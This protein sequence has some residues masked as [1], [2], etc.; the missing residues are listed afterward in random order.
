MAARTSEELGE[1]DRRGLLFVNIGAGAVIIRIG[2]WVEYTIG[3][4]WNP[5]KYYF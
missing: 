5:S 1:S 2:V 4:I 3:M